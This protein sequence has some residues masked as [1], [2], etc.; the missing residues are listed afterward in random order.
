MKTK[1]IVKS[2]AGNYYLQDI[3]NNQL[4]FL[5]P[6]LKVYFDSDYPFKENSYYAKKYLFLN[7]KLRSDNHPWKMFDR[8]MTARIVREQVINTKQI[9]FEVT[10][11]CNINCKY[12]AY[13]DMYDY[14]DTKRS[15]KLKYEHAKKL[16][17][18]LN[19]LW[20]SNEYP[21]IDKDI[22]LGFYGGEPLLNISL[23][24]RIVDYIDSTKPSYVNIRYF[25]TTNGVLLE[26]HI[27]Y[28]TSKNFHVAISLDGNKEHNGFRVDKNEKNVFDTVSNNIDLIRQTYPKY[29][30]NNVSILSVLHSKNSVKD[31]MDYV[32]KRFDKKASISEV[33]STGIRKDKIKEF[34]KMYK[35][36]KESI[37]NVEDKKSLVEELFMG[38]PDTFSLMFYLYYFSGNIIN[39]YVGFYS[40]NENRKWL[41]TGTCVPFSKKIFLT[42]NGKI[43][44][45]ESIGHQYS[46]GKVND[47]GVELN[48]QEIADKYNEI[49]SN[50]MKQCSVCYRS[51]GC[52]QCIFNIENV[53]TKPVCKT[54]MNLSDFKYYLSKNIS[55]MEQSSSLYSKVMEDV[56][57]Y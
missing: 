51:K 20:K 9:T 11:R 7:K 53:L 6:E 41:P 43:L 48:F 54:N 2:D 19:L 45:C 5:P 26:K 3:T 1:I 33:N 31:V 21:S 44:P 32:K 29:Y 36:K 55:L 52:L 17:D 57:L 42:V 56:T 8:K 22:A 40:S 37:N 14:Y 13:G 10:E 28:L 18:Y 46:L 34:N 4:I 35:N 15:N 24:K 25:M 47:N 30:E 39:D 50:I 16:I 27:T 23:I 49:F 12:C 38:D